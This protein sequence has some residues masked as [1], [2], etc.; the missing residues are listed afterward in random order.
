LLVEGD[1]RQQLGD[2]MA[3]AALADK[4]DADADVLDKVRR[5]PLRAP[6]ILVVVAQ[7]KEHP[8]VPEIEQIIT[9]GA[10]ANN[11]VTAAFAMGVGAYWRTGGAA[12][13]PVVKRGLGLTANEAIVGF[14][15]LGTPQVKLRPAPEVNVADTFERW[16]VR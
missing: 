15:Y 7:I 12:Y 1:A 8:K 13:H 9:A 3:Q 6:T 14:I 4:P 10:A 11:L 16:G 5:K 2:I